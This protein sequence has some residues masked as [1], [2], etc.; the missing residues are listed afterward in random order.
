MLKLHSNTFHDTETTTS[1]GKQCGHT[2][3][4]NIPPKIFIRTAISDAKE[5]FL[6]WNN[7]ASSALHLT[8]FPTNFH[9]THAFAC[10]NTYSHKSIQNGMPIKN[11]HDHGLRAFQGPTAFCPL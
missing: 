6:C 7:N 9:G 2:K 1:K 8:I 11:C 10:R 4:P 3:K 5:K